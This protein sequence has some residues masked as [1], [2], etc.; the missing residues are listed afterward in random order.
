MHC[1]LQA[2]FN[3]YS[4]LTEPLSQATETT[5]VSYELYDEAYPTMKEV[6]KWRQARL[7]LTEDPATGTQLCFNQK[8]S[9]SAVDNWLRSLF[10]EAFDFLDKYY[11]LQV[12]PKPGNFHWALMTRHR[13]T[14]TL[15]KKPEAITG[16]DLA[17]ARCQMGRSAA[18]VT[19]HFGQ[20]LCTSRQRP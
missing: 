4:D 8:W 12:G 11:G 18:M 1:R 3:S 5:P 14:L 16:E 10:R 17:R 15:I 20:S 13:Q 6:E 2:L 7:V 9:P 19:L